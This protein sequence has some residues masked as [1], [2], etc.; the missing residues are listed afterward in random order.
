M[1]FPVKW[2]HF[3]KLLAAIRVIHNGIFSHSFWHSVQ[4]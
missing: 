2:M 1:Q 4:F 3:I